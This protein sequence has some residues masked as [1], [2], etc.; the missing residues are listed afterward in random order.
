MARGAKEEQL[1]NLILKQ[2]YKIASGFAG[3]QGKWLPE[4]TAAPPLVGIW[5]ICHCEWRT[6]EGGAFVIQSPFP[7]P[8]AGFLLLPP[9]AVSSLEAESEDFSL[10]GC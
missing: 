2:I 5:G 3:S 4:P 8:L 7:S 6:G 1:I 9:L 10:L